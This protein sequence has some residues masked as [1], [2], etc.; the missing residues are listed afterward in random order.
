MPIQILKIRNWL[1]E[2]WLTVLVSVIF[3]WMIHATGKVITSGIGRIEN[4]VDKINYAIAWV[5]T[6]KIEHGKL[7]ATVLQNSDSVLFLRSDVDL[8][9]KEIADVKIGLLTYGIDLK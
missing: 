2:K 9:M 8:C 3:L 5:D 7:N 1:L 4:K 6:D